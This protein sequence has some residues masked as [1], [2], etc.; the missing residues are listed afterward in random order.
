MQKKQNNTK[1]REQKWKTTRYLLVPG[2]RSNVLQI[3]CVSVKEC[4]CLNFLHFCLLKAPIDRNVFSV[5]R[6]DWTDFMVLY[7]VSIFLVIFFAMYNCT[8]MRCLHLPD[9]YEIQSHNVTSWSHMIWD[10]EIGNIAMQGCFIIIQLSNPPTNCKVYC[11]SRKDIWNKLL[12]GITKME[13]ES[14]TVHSQE[15]YAQFLSKSVTIV[16]I[17]VECPFLK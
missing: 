17:S 1:R 7:L 12:H 15:W 14:L 5:T 9:F 16:T 6:R 8:M 10:W 11:V 3:A 2:W 4:P 13:I